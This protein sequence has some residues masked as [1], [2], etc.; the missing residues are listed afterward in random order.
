MFVEIHVY[1]SRF[2]VCVCF[3]SLLIQFG[4]WFSSVITFDLRTKA[5]VV[6]IECM[7][8]CVCCVV[9]WKFAS[10]FFQIKMF[11][12]CCVLR[13]PETFYLLDKN[14]LWFVAV[15]MHEQAMI[16]WKMHAK[17]SKRCERTKNSKWKKLTYA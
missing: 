11:D 10:F 3:L 14:E 9:I 8:A 17:R 6:Y 1:F 13:Q 5:H 12:G 4:S 2:C 15:N 16:L 7:I